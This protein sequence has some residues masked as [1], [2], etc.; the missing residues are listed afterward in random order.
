MRVW[1]SF[2]ALSDG[3]AADDVARR[4]MIFAALS[5]ASDGVALSP[6][7]IDPP[8]DATSALN[9]TVTPSYCAPWISMSP[10]DFSF[11]AWSMIPSHVLAGF[12]TRSLRYQSSC[13]LEF[14]GAAQRR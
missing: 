14:A 4:R 12:G 3:S 7:M 9:H 5:H 11:S 13:V 6:L 2:A 1:S 8:A 10:L